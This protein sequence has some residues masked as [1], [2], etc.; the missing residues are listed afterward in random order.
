M[1][2]NQHQI[3]HFDFLNFFKIK[4]IAHHIKSLLL[5]CGDQPG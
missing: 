4:N 5:D 2:Y 1:Q 3:L